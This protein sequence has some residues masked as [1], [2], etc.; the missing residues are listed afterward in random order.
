MTS[1]RDILTAATVA[2]IVVAISFSVAFAISTGA[3][4]VFG[5]PVPYIAAALALGVN[6]AAFVPAAFQKS[7][8]FYDLTGTFTYLSLI[9]LAVVT[10]YRARGLTIIDLVTAALVVVWA[11]RLGSFLVA[12][13]LRA[14]KDGRFDEMKTRPARFFVAWTL[15]A[16]WV[17][18][19]VLAALTILT[20][21]RAL[22]MIS[23][24]VV[25]GWSLFATG[26]AIEIVADRQ[27]SAFSRHGE[28]AGRF[29]TTGLWAWS[30]H[31]NYAGEILLWS[32]MCVSAFDIARGPLVVVVLSPVFV[33]LLLRF[34]SGVPLL[35]ARADAK[36]G[37]E[38]A[39]RAY[40][41]K[42]PVLF[43]RPPR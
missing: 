17:F 35:E 9:A 13:I 21:D 42:T 36:W 10:T 32:G 24:A 37:E 2:L 28:N 15:Q 22:P 11:L 7:E 31:P 8:R 16:L 43:L 29:I 20:R 39:Y 27:K 14:G 19:T 41:A 4:V 33:F 34:I 1:A 12:R 6:W 25:I 18:L 38:A 30:R 23:P 3:V 26:F 40:K 5:V